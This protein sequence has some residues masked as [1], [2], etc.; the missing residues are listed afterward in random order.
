MVAGLDDL[1]EAIHDVIFG[2]TLHRHGVFVHTHQADEMAAAIIAL[3]AMQ[4]FG[5]QRVIEELEQTAAMVRSQHGAASL[6]A[7]LID[8]RVAVL[9]GKA[10]R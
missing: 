2:W 5:D 3:P 7:R 10:D 1:H 8:T 6:A 4:R 9:R